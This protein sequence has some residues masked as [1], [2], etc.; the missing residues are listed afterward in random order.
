MPKAAS[1]TAPN[2]TPKTAPKAAPKPAGRIAGVLL[3]LS[4]VVFVG[5]AAIG[6][7]VASLRDLR[8]SGLPL[9]FVT[10]TTS[11]PLR[12]LLEQLR[13]LGIEA[14]SRDIVTPATAARRLVRERGLSPRL[15]VHPDL[16]EDFAPPPA[17][18]ADAVILGDAGRAF[19]YEALNEAFRLIEGGAAFIALARNRTF[20][21]ADGQLSLDAGPFVA[22]LEYATRRDALLIGKPSAAFYAA[23]VADLGTAA[24]E[25]A[26]IGDDVEADVAGALEAGM[27]GLLVRT[28]KYKHGDEGR[29]DPGPTATLAD[30]RQAVD[31][32]LERR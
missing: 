30:L 22:A 13:R 14:G 23:A 18:P 31:W 26:M 10:N 15:V 1:K 3:D 29:I 8:A 32:V 9:R 11:K 2:T 21:D 5:D 4:G 27:A 16:L 17:R 6:E 7:A 28:G 25:T 20:K 12:A 19:S 24:R